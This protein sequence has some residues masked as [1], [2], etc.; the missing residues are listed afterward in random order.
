M[1]IESI[2]RTKPNKINII[3][4]CLKG[5][6]E[7][8]SLILRKYLIQN[9]KFYQ[10]YG[11]K[12]NSIEIMNSERTLLFL[13]SFIIDVN[14]LEAKYDNNDKIFYISSNDLS[15]KNIGIDEKLISNDKFNLDILMKKYSI[16]NENEYQDSTSDKFDFIESG[17]LYKRLYPLNRISNINYNI[18]ELYGDNNIKYDRVEFVIY[19]KESVDSIE[20]HIK[21][22]KNDISKIFNFIDNNNQQ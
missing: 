10:C 20:E 16:N 4:S 21:L 22:F 12:S 5:Y 7:T 19:T 15:N 3:L 1:N 6:G 11:F 14:Y 8:I 13:N 18:M 2:S 9:N 17:E